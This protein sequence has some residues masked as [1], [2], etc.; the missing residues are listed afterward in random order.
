MVAIMVIR[1]DKVAD[2]LAKVPPFQFLDEEELR[3]VAGR[4]EFETYPMD[5]VVHREGGSPSLSLSV[6]RKGGVKLSIRSEEGEW[7]LELFLSVDDHGTS[8]L[9]LSL[10]G[11][12]PESLAEEAWGKILEH[13]GSN[14]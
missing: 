6:I 5:A 1:I 9:R 13:R 11:G 14:A 3:E 4:A 7:K 10:T 12:T 2:F 8:P